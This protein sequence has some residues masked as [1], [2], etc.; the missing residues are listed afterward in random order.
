MFSSLKKWLGAWSC[1]PWVPNNTRTFICTALQ[2]AEKLTSEKDF[3]SVG[4]RSGLCAIFSVPGSHHEWRQ[5]VQCYS[6]CVQTSTVKY[7][8]DYY[9]DARVEW[10]S[11]SRSS[12]SLQDD[13]WTQMCCAVGPVYHDLWRFCVLEVI[14]FFFFFLNDV[15]QTLVTFM[16]ITPLYPPEVSVWRQLILFYSC[17]HTLFFRGDRI[18]SF[19]SAG[20]AHASFLH[21]F[22]SFFKAHAYY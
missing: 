1:G 14:S 13:Q 21:F 3:I 7:M 15:L 22:F 18:S 6:V 12:V 11:F 17:A 9:K 2:H 10:V 16:W 5:V 20:D 8:T 4:W 19:S